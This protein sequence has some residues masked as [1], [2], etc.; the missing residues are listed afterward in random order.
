MSSIGLKGDYIIF[1]AMIEV[2]FSL[3]IYQFTFLSLQCEVGRAMNA[4][5][6]LLY[7]PPTKIMVLGPGCSLACEPLAKGS[8]EWNITM[9]SA[10][11]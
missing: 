4:M 8:Y 3:T 6:K 1:S 10:F 5:Y 7:T 11:L 2:S 9:V